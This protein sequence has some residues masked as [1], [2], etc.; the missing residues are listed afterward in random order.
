MYLIRLF[1]LVIIA[2]AIEKLLNYKA[3]SRNGISILQEILAS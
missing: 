3:A 2:L 1:F